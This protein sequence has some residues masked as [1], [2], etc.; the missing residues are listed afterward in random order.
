MADKHNIVYV[1]RYVDIEGY[2]NDIPYKK[3]GIT[4]NENLNSRVQEISGTKS[5]IKV[6]C[7]SAWSHDKAREIENA[8]HIFL[9]DV[10]SDGEWFKDENDSLVERMQ[11][12]MQLL[13]AEEI[14]I[15]DEHDAYTQKIL[16][17]E[18]DTK[19]PLYQKLLGEITFL[20]HNPL[21]TRLAPKDGLTIF[22]SQLTFSVRYRKSGAHSLHIGKCKE[23]FEQL[24][25]F[26]DAKG[27]DLK[28][29]PN[30]QNARVSGVSSEE[31]ANIIN[32][33]E[34]EFKEFI[35]EFN[36]AT[37]EGSFTE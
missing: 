4:R 8:M 5:P 24:K 11:P 35:E 36:K 2:V 16:K 33:V 27:F 9:E 34:A 7:V 32:D 19:T 10:R 15:K 28:S 13:G 22:G 3:I 23:V 14:I 30:I 26:F 1:M 20:L 12:I 37:K 21:P 29:S 17:Q 18:S 25:L 6:Q 31:I